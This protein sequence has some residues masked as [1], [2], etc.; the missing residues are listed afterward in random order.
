[1]MVASR[2]L[3]NLPVKKWEFVVSCT[4]L[5]CYAPISRNAFRAIFDC[6][7]L[8]RLINMNA[9]DTASQKYVMQP[10]QLFFFLC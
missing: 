9:R 5:K 6:F 4:H 8:G 1:M 10:V 3:M 7:F 2:P